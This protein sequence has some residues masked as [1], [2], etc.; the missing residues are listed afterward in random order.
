MFASFAAPFSENS[1]SF[2]L[3]LL[4]YFTIFS[5]SRYFYEPLTPSIIFHKS[6][7]LQFQQ[8]RSALSFA[9]CRFQRLSRASFSLCIVYQLSSWKQRLRKRATIQQVSCFTKVF[10]FTSTGQNVP[11]SLVCSRRV[12]IL[13]NSSFML[14]HSLFTNK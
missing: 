11:L 2:F 5:R 9:L 7:S 6:K 8:E 3:R 4:F 10:R 12:D 1:I 13:R 14:L